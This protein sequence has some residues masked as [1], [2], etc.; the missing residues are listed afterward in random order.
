MLYNEWLG[1]FGINMTSRAS[2][3]KYMLAFAQSGEEGEGIIKII[4]IILLL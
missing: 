2:C 4:I 1:V 3:Q